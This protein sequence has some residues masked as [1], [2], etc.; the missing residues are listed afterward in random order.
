MTFNHEKV[1]PT[2]SGSSYAWE[3]LNLPPIKPEVSSPQLSNLAPRIAVNYAR[4]DTGAGANAKTFE[5]WRQVSRWASDLHDP[6]AVPD[7]SVTA[8]A[9]E[10]TA[11][12]KTDL[13][14]IRAIAQFVQRLQYISIDIG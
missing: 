1:E 2:I 11:N 14:R 5:D 12:S 3:L 8:K 10:L 6:Q 4:G 9:R 7:E 13:D